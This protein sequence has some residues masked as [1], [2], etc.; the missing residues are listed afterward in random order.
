MAFQKGNIPWNKGTKYTESQINKLDL[1]GL[2]LGH[3]IGEKHHLWKGD[4]ASYSAIHYWISRQL[5]KAKIC[6]DCGST[7]KCVWANISG[8]YKRTIEDYK[9]L[10][11]SCHAIFDNTGLKSWQTRRGVVTY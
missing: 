1:A 9:S 2:S 8:L 4:K 11:Y 10:C 5:G 6:A 7:K 3:Q